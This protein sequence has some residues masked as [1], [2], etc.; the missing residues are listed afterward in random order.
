MMTGEA[1][2]TTCPPHPPAKANAALRTWKV[3]ALPVPEEFRPN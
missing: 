2:D 3:R 1:S